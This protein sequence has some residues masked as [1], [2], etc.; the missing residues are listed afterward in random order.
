MCEKA[1]EIERK[2]R[3]EEQEREELIAKIDQLGS[4]QDYPDCC[5]HANKSISILPVIFKRTFMSIGFLNI[6]YMERKF[7][8]VMY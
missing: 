4:V 8:V 5:I 2:R 6:V 7:T 1:A 3:R